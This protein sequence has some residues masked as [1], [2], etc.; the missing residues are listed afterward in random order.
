MSGIV[1]NIQ[2]YSLHD[3]PGIRTIVFLKGCYLR[4]RWCSNP[5]SQEFYPQVYLDSKKCIHNKGCSF[6]CAVCRWNAVDDAVL[7]HTA[8]NN[9]GECV[10]LC[11]SG[12]LNIYGKTMTVDEVIDKVEKES[13]FYDRSKGGLTLSGG[14]PFAQG[15]FAIDILKEAKKRKINTAAE[16]CGFCNRNILREA[17]RYLDYIMF[18]I[19]C[20]DSKKHT[21]YTG[22]SNQI[23]L[24]NLEMLFNDFPSLH[25]H[26]RTPVIP[27]FNDN[28]KDISKIAEFLKGRNN[29]TYE[30]LPYHRFGQ[31]KYK[32]LGKD[33]PDF[34]E[35]LNEQLFKELKTLL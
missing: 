21:E 24:E 31:D 29:Y 4:C 18:D 10:A 28:K 14:E 9:C 35:K 7:D 2:P 23:I 3:G 8:C 33:Y 30:L 27:T 12:A 13:S 34:P 26:I 11:P 32:L 25:K 20:M 15:E 22:Q 17:A 6:C 16:T 5:E 1:F 19:K